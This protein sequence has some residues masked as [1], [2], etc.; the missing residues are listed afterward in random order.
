M[1]RQRGGALS[2]LSRIFDVRLVLNGKDA[3]DCFAQPVKET[4]GTPGRSI[5]FLQQL[6][7]GISRCSGFGLNGTGKLI[8]DA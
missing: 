8:S 6:M 1:P 2:Q 5:T 4:P 3:G 7:F